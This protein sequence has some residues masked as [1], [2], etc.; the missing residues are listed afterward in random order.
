MINQRTLG[1]L[2]PGGVVVNVARGPVIVEN[3]LIAMLQNGHLSGAGLD[4][5]ETEPLSPTSPLW[6]MDNVIITPHVGAQSENRLPDT[7]DF[8]CDNLRRYLANEELLNV[9]DKTVGFPLRT[10]SD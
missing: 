2:K 7:I 6:N 10:A 4:V 9:V 3:D 8:V 5:V 1:L